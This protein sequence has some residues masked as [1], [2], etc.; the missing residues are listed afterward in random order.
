MTGNN[1]SFTLSKQD[2]SYIHGDFKYCS[3][4]VT[5][6]ETLVVLLHFPY[7]QLPN[8]QENFINIYDGKNETYS[9]LASYCGS[10]A[11]E[12]RKEMVSTT[13][14]VYVFLKYR[15]SSKNAEIS[16]AFR[17]EYSS[18][19]KPTSTQNSLIISMIRMAFWKS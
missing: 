16:M 10:N 7:L 4:L 8:C 19:V 12:G 17:A 14:S 15:S 13:N 1:G 5:V 11:T 18:L 2:L 9:L 3:W 6:N